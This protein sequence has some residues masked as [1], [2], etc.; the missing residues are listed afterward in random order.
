MVI[1]VMAYLIS[2]L[3]ISFICAGCNSSHSDVL[4]PTSDGKEAC[5]NFISSMKN[6]PYEMPNQRK[7]HILKNYPNLNVH[8]TK[9]SVVEILGE[10]DCSDYLRGKEPPQK[11]LGSL[12]LYYLYKD[13]RL[14]NEKKDRGIEIF[15]GTDGKVR[16]VVPRNIE[17]LAEKE[18]PGEK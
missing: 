5:N 8:M 9:E 14:V 13:S 17:G 11:Y 18:Q 3:M 2:I 6:L 4:T 12:W 1:N 15:F 7:S 10:P 16:W